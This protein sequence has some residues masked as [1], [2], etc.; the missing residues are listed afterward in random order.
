MGIL[1]DPYAVLCL[2]HCLSAE[3]GFF[4]ATGMFTGFFLFFLPNVTSIVAVAIIFGTLFG[5]NYGFLNFILTTL[6]LQP[7]EWLNSPFW[8]KMLSHP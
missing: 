3:F 7:I 8:L 4:C 1:D 6:G 5:N 2:A